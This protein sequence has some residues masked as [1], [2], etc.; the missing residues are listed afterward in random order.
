LATVVYSCR[1]L[2]HLERSFEFIARNDPHSALS[3]A[4]AIRTAVE[5][6]AEHPL[7]GRPRNDDLRELVISFGRTGYLALYR[8]LP[9]IEQVQVLAIRHQRELDYPP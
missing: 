2:E 4:R 1:A 7:I 9:H 8:F 5:V 6:L 3:A